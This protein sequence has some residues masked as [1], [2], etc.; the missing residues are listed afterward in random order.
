M[1][2][3]HFD[4]INSI[5][6]ISSFDGIVYELSN[7]IISEPLY[8]NFILKVVKLGINDKYAIK[9]YEDYKMKY[10]LNIIS[11]KLKF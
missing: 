6:D 7:T 4:T 10:Y 8:L 9:F 11:K 1:I 5:L 3:F 2:Y